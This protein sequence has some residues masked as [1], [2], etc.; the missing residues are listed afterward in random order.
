MCAYKLCR[1]E[2]KYWGM[3]TKIERFIHEVALRKTMVRAHR[4]VWCWQDEYNGMTMDD[5]RRLEK[6]TQL[7]LAEKMALAKQAENGGIKSEKEAEQVEIEATSSKAV[8]VVNEDVQKRDSWADAISSIG[9]EH[10]EDDSSEDEFYDAQEEVT[11]ERLLKSSSMEFIVPSDETKQDGELATSFDKK[12]E[13]YKRLQ[14]DPPL[15]TAS[16]PSTALSSSQQPCRTT[17]LFLVAHGGSVVESGSELKSTD[18]NTLRSTI[19]AVL[20]SH[21]P[22]MVGRLAVRLV[23]C[24]PICS[25]ALELLSTLSPTFQFPQV[26]RIGN[27]AAIL[28]ANHIPVSC[29]PLFATGKL[30]SYSES[31]LQMVKKCNQVYNEFLQSE[32]GVSFRGRV[33]IIGDSVGSLLVYDALIKNNPFLSNSQLNELSEEEE[34]ISNPDLCSDE[35]FYSTKPASPRSSNRY[36]ASCPV[37]RRTSTG[38]YGGESGKFNFEVYDFFMFGAPLGLLLAFRRLCKTDERQNVIPKPSCQ[39]IYNIF[40][41]TDPCACRLEPLI[42]EKFRLISPINVSRFQ[43]FPR[44]NG[45]SV[46]VAEAIQN[47]MGLFSETEISVSDLTAVTAKWWGTKRIDYVLY[48]PDA[49]KEINPSAL[50]YLLQSSFWESMDAIAFLLRQLLSQ[51]DSDWRNPSANHLSGRSYKPEEPT[52]KWLKRRTAIKLHNTAPNHRANDVLI[53]EDKKQ[54]LTAKFMYGILDVALSSERVD[55]HVQRSPPDGEW[56]F[57]D[58]VRTD[59]SGRVTYEVPEDKRLSLGIYPVVMTVRGDHTTAD[60][61]LAVLPPKTETVVF[62][63]DGSFTASVSIRGKDP[64]VRAGAVD[65]VRMWQDLGY[66]ILYI[67]ARPDMQHRVV[68]SWLAQHNF[69]YGMVAFMDGLTAEPMKQ[70]TQYLQHLVKNANIKIHAAYGSCKDIQVYQT[71]EVEQSHTFIIGKPSKKHQ[72]EVVVLTGGYAQHLNDLTTHPGARPASG[73]ARLFLKKTCFSLPGQTQKSKKS[74]RKTASLPYRRNTTREAEP[75]TPTI[76]V[77]HI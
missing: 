5:I 19:D 55:I 27:D 46:H 7:A 12:L 50:P 52:E 38:S 21:Y 54:L 4:Q 35:E 47:H 20:A 45:Q 23:Q 56:C 57:L 65:V 53:A 11:R 73:N 3:Q 36:P 14:Q 61:S 62:S 18:V 24:P 58:T 37:S 15:T 33:C 10:I 31:V 13:R 48:C 69:P 44:G 63:I 76:N 39:Q 2:F 68:V 8:F 26:P 41:A 28:A 34:I 66:L 64:K 43:N 6:E 16:G 40:Y 17:V 51:T 77:K 60:F 29:V 74:V 75:S 9:M 71:L 59:S 49:L 72:K 22:A 67:T 30:H 70:K 1:V 25:E 42:S 32:E